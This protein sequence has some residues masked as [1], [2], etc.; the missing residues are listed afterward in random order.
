MPLVLFRQEILI[1][2]NASLLLLL[3]FLLIP[4]S[5]SGQE[6]SNQLPRTIQTSLNERFR[7]WNFAEVT[8]EIDRFLKERGARPELIKG[9]FDGDA[10][11]DYAVLIVYGRVF[12]GVGEVIGKKESV[13]AFLRRG[14]GFRSYVLETNP[15]N[16]EFYLALAKKGGDG[17]DF[18]A[19]KRFKYRSDAIA[20][21]FFE[22]AGGSYIYKNG[23]FRY[24]TTSD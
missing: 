6:L 18:H 19:D 1:D 24:L 21:A 20:V 11:L 4:I 14:K 5:A 15:S 12:N 13:I 17:Y 8:E 22:K 23:R 7:G 10:R 16:P 3:H 9:D 2:M